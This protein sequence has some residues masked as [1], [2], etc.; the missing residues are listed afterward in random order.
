M[1]CPVFFTFTT[2]L[3]PTPVFH[4][5]KHFYMN[6]TGKEPLFWLLVILI[7]FPQISETIYTP[8]L[9][10]LAAILHTSGNWMQASLSI[11][12]A[13][14]AAGVVLW[15][16]LADYWGRRPALLCGV[17]VFVLGSAGC[18]LS[19]TV[20]LFL[21]SR[22]IQA[23]GAASGLIVTQTILL[24]CYTNERRARIFASMFAVL[25]FSP[26]AGP[27]AGGMIAGYIGVRAVFITLVLMGL[28]I[29]ACAFYWLGE[30]R[31]ALQAPAIP[32]RQTARRM[33]HDPHIWV[34]GGFIGIM[35]GMVFSFYAEAPFIFIHHLGFSTSEY[36]FIGICEA[37]SAFMAAALNRRLMK[38]YSLNAIIRMG[39]LVILGGSLFLAAGST[40]H[41]IPPFL[42]AACFVAGNFIVLCGTGL[43]LPHCMSSALSGYE[44]TLG[45]AG[46][47]LGLYYYILIGL[48]TG[49]MSWLH[50]ENV[51]TMPLFFCGL[52]LLMIVLYAA[53]PLRS[54]VS[55][56]KY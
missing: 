56:T 7:G 35:N 16:M 15:G 47:L 26:A 18:L 1:R 32:V 13:G 29:G 23:A 5:P 25:A 30:T 24:D 11:Y 38:R 42:F 10:Q 22:F 45:V 4:Q 19:N 43:A 55:L 36:G 39:L 40:A 52:S 27:L 37:S 46:A 21:M 9:P 17:A 53:S 44:Q 20:P 34:S 31:P 54:N 41:S 2:P 12:F 49:G 8:S 50:S 6:R 48:V 14:F 33:L 51:G 28:V 3:F